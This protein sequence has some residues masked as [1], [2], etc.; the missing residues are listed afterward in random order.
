MLYARIHLPIST[1]DVS[2]GHFAA[3]VHGLES[4]ARQTALAFLA[5]G[6]AAEALERPLVVDRRRRFEASVPSGRSRAWEGPRE[7]GWWRVERVSG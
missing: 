6:G 4:I 2:P 1:R 5:L 3:N 7:G